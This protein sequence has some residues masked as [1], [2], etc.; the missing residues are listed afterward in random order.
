MESALSLHR[1]TTHHWQQRTNKRCSVFHASLYLPTN[2][3]CNLIRYHAKANCRLLACLFRICSYCAGRWNS[4]SIGRFFQ[5]S[6]CPKRWRNTACSWTPRHTCLSFK[7]S[8]RRP[9]V[10]LL[11]K[12]VAGKG[13]KRC[14]LNWTHFHCVTSCMIICDAGHGWP[15]MSE[16]SSAVHDAEA[17]SRTAEQGPHVRA[18]GCASSA[19]PP[20]GE[21]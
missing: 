5:Q 2:T 3:N 1:R 13:G 18:H 6:G 15:S 9:T 11:A 12:S 8:H 19:R 14:N 16:L 17:R 7:R 21:H 20:F 10:C 4:S